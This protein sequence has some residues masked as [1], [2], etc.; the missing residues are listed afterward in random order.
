M[1][2]IDS[3]PCLSLVDTGSQVSTVSQ[4]FLEEYLTNS[5]VKPL[6]QIDLKIQGAGG[7]DVPFLGYVEADISFPDQT[8]GVTNSVSAKVLV[9]TNTTFNKQVSLVIGT[10]VMGRCRDIC[11]S[12]HGNKF[13][14]VVKPDLAWRMAYK[15]L[16][17]QH[18]Q[19]SKFMKK[20]RLTTGSTE[21]LVVR[22]NETS[23][24]WTSV[25]TGNKGA[26]FPVLLERES[27]ELPENLQIVPTLVSIECDGSDAYVPVEIHNS[28]DDDIQISPGTVVCA[29][30]LVDI[31]DAV[32]DENHDNNEEHVPEID[33]ASSPMSQEQKKIAE[34]FFQEWE[35]SI[36]SKGPNDLGCCTAVKHEIPLYDNTPFK[37]RH[38]RIPPAQY[39][40]VR[41]HLKDMLNAGVI[42]ESHS[43]FSSPVVLVRKRD[44]SLRF[45]I[46]F[47]KLNSRTVKDAY[48]LPRIDE[49]LEAMSGSCWFSTLDLKSGYWQLE[50]AE[51]DKKKTAFTVGPLGFYECNRMAFGL[52]N[53]PATFQRLMEH[54]MG[55]LNFSECIVYIDDI[56]VFSRTFE[57]HIER[58]GDVFSRLQEFGLKLKLSKCS[59]FQNKVKYL[60]H[61]I[62][63]HGIEPT[64]IKFNP[65]KP[66]Q[67]QLASMNSGRSLDFPV[68]TVSLS[69]IMPS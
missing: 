61:I 29:P 13:L 47:R 38:R 11:T 60:G 36:F 68:I 62:S 26:T 5:E 55:D 10:N 69:R 33:F 42:R 22:A 64:L 44:G 65:S 25:K 34:Q 6:S 53:A 15:F 48:A 16:N 56:I 3:V 27:S 12:L 63:S 35:R 66:G 49:A 23:V 19:V 46:D 52:T 58:L 21:T 24:I 54:C 4:M 8:S 67:C 1:A 41:D 37:Q 43:P 40:E 57:E 20:C 28:S 59:F 17:Q 39:Q 51:E 7:Q 32:Q 9:V 50:V 45:C 30:Q 31:C 14:Q 2:Y 18:K